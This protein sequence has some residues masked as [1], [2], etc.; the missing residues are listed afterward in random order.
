MRGCDDHVSQTRGGSFPN[1]GRAGGSGDAMKPCLVA[2]D[3]RKRRLFGGG[4]LNKAFAD[5]K[6]SGRVSFSPLVGVGVSGAN[7]MLPSLTISFSKAASRTSRALL[8]LVGAWR[9]FKALRRSVVDISS[10]SFRS[11]AKV[12]C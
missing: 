8:R 10:G 5:E 3:A 9:I 2:V 6:K 11:V 1:S 7:T 4:L 12:R